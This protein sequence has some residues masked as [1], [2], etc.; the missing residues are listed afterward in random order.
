ME[1]IYKGQNGVCRVRGKAGVRVGGKGREREREEREGMEGELTTEWDLRAEIQMPLEL[2]L[3]LR[4]SQL[5]R[6]L[7]DK[8]SICVKLLR[9]L[10]SARCVLQSQR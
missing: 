4:C 1:R 9:L 10:Q 6:R 5:R 3:K 7:C 8:Y 2:T